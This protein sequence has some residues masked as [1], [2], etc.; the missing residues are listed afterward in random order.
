[1]WKPCEAG[2]RSQAGNRRCQDGS[3]TRRP[4]GFTDGAV[5]TTIG[6]M[7]GSSKRCRFLIVALVAALIAA[8]CSGSEQVTEPPDGGADTSA[9]LGAPVSQVAP[10][11]EFLGELAVVEAGPTQVTFDQDSG[12]FTFDD[13]ATL[14]V[15]A[16]AFA[17]P[18]E[19]TALLVDLD[20]GRY[21]DN[22]P[23][24]RA[25]VLA[26]A[27][28][29][30]LAEPLTLEIPV[31]SDN[32]SVA[33]LRDDRWLPLEVDAANT[34]SVAIQ[35][36]SEVPTVLLERGDGEPE[37]NVEADD[38]LRDA[39]FFRTCLDMH[40]G[41]FQDPEGARG[42]GVQ[43]AYNVCVRALISAR[44]PF[45]E[46]VSTACVADR[47]GGEI[48]LRAAVDA[49]I[50]DSEDP[51]S[52]Q[53]STEAASAEEPEAPTESG[54]GEAVADVAGTYEIGR[55]EGQ[56]ASYGYEV[57]G[58]SLTATVAGSQFDVV[59]TVALDDPIVVDGISG[60]TTCVATY[61]FSVMAESPY[62]DLMQF[63]L[64]ASSVDDIGYAGSNCGGNEDNAVQNS[65]ALIDGG[66]V[67]IM[68]VTVEAGTLTGS[69][70]WDGTANNLVRAG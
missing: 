8:A 12:A 58:G 17:E 51:V 4:W 66:F 24:G 41:W 6:A 65:Q 43:L 21:L 30:A 16:G 40:M 42:L 47:I 7:N 59:G 31:S 13:G 35:H 37:A 33:Q 29:V 27:E 53:G 2:C 23:Q 52:D 36:F 32:V 63:A 39:V 15:P 68:T 45:G 64:P 9:A 19:V 18:T 3:A 54:E 55:A 48:D 34:V 14:Q 26:T 61:T 11:L 5:A 44:T 1:V 38:G 46:S 70:D 22:P 28:D 50:D 67:A 49:C 60:E 69:V 20:Y 57:A 10:S 25:Y 56:M 62:D